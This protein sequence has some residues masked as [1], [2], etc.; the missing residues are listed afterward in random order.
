ARPAVKVPPTCVVEEAFCTF[1]ASGLDSVSLA[2]LK[3]KRTTLTLSVASSATYT[4]L[5]LAGK[6]AGGAAGGLPRT[7]WPPDLTAPWQLLFCHGGV[8]PV[9]GTISQT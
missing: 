5:P 1:I 2:G 4:Y 8:A 9:A 7:I 6:P 3:M